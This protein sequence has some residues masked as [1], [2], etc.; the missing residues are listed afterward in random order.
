[1]MNKKYLKGLFLTMLLAV[2]VLVMAACGGAQPAA[3]PA[4]EEA[5]P[6]QEEAA[7]AEA[8]A[9]QPAPSAPSG[10]KITI[11]LAE[12][13]WT[14]S[15]VNVAVAK[16]LLQ[17]QL[18]YTVENVT[19]DENA[20]WPALAT[21][22]LSASLEVWPSGHA[23]NVKQYI[24][25]QKVVEKAGELGVVGKIGWYIP[26]YMLEEHPELATWEGFKDPANAALFKTAETGDKGQFLG[27]DP[28]W[29]QYDEQII[30]NLDLNFQVVY[31]GSEQAILA[32]VD[33]VYSRKEPILIYFYKPHSAFAKYDLTNVTLPENTEECYA[34]AEAGGVDCDYPTDVLF[35]IVWA[36]LKNKA[37]DAYQL[38]SKMNYSTDDQVVMIAD[39]DTNGKTAEEA[40]RDWLGK[41]EDKWKAWLP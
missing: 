13:P 15:L 6:A 27:G 40:A 25:D 37:P 23:E 3:E 16:I 12:N 20:Q 9:E 8:E 34:K 31:A 1:M 14:G 29:V 5:A 7:P 18:G 4:K 17:E 10:E 19:I 11:K 36:D 32:A 30:K 35:K 39:V 26:T 21:G 33:S 28:S 2:I 22:D 41:N 24:D 38:L